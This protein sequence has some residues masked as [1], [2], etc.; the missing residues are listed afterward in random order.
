MRA[1]AQKLANFERL[2]LAG[3]VR[4]FEFLHERLAFAGALEEEA[5]RLDFL[6]IYRAN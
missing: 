6:Q 4:D 2:A 5:L 3:C 1:R